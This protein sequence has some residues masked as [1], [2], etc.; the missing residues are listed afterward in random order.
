MEAAVSTLLKAGRKLLTSRSAEEDPDDYPFPLT[1]R[2]K[3]PT[4]GNEEIP[5]LNGN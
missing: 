4:N 5:A 2:T 3:Q 1:L